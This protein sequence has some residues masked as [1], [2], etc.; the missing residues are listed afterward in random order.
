MMPL[1]AKLFERYGHQE[2]PAEIMW[3]QHEAE[4]REFGGAV[5]VVT[6]RAE[7][8]LRG[9][10]A[11]IRMNNVLYSRDTGYDYTWKKGLPLYFEVVFYSPIELAMRYRCRMIDY[12]YGSD[13]TKASR[14]CDLHPRLGYVK[15]F[16]EKSS[17]VIERLCAELSCADAWPLHAARSAATVTPFAPPLRP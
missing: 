8:V 17:D 13:E 6:A 1:E 4:A 16:D 3:R 14:G 11:F 10:A 2:Y 12:S 7:G 9:Y 15:A 5:H